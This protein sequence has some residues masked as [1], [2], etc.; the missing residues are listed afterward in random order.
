MSGNVE[1]GALK[2]RRSRAKIEKGG[3]RKEELN[4]SMICN[5]PS[6]LGISARFSMMKGCELVIFK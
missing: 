6:R 2:K 5:I 3:R 1:P 4:T